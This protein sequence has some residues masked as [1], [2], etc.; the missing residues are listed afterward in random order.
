MTAA[1]RSAYSKAYSSAISKAQLANNAKTL[2]QRRLQG[3]ATASSKLAIKRQQV[4]NARIKRNAVKRTYQQNVYNR[5]SKPLTVQSAHSLFKAQSVAQNRQ[6]A[7]KG[8]AIH[9]RTTTMQ[10]LTNAEAISQEA[11]VQRASRARL[12]SSVKTPK[13]TSKRG[14]TGRSKYSSIG[15]SAGRS[16]A[17]RVSSTAKVRKAGAYILHPVYHGDEWIAAGNDQGEENCVAVAVANHLLY[18]HQIRVE[19][20][21]VVDLSWMITV[22]TACAELW[23]WN[24]WSLH[25][26]YMN[27][28]HKKKPEDAMPGHLV[29]FDVLVEGKP[30]PHCGV[31]L[32]DSRV[33]SWG[34]VVP[35]DRADIDEVWE[36]KWRT[37]D[38]E[39]SSGA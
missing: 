32:A 27:G 28:W 8:E 13:A 39:S 11:R 3:A 30:V 17:S 7:F 4:I 34:E 6:F 38:G 19:D 14:A 10:T 26:A 22:P 1:Q 15:A 24:L 37:V 2:Q 25:G 5:A 36:I 31:L 29:G 33:V 21:D 35:L 18:H 9:L 12:K 16:A 20:Q 23:S